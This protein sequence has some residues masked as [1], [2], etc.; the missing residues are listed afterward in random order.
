[1]PKQMNQN[2]RVTMTKTTPDRASR[3]RLL[4]PL[5]LAIP[6]AGASAPVHAQGIDQT[7]ALYS[8]LAFSVAGLVVVILGVVLFRRLGRRKHDGLADDSGLDIMALKQKQLLTPEEMRMVSAAIARRMEEK[9]QKRKRS[10]GI[11]T[12]NLLHDPEVQ[13]LREEAEARRSGGGM[14]P[15]AMA[16]PRTSYFS[17]PATDEGPVDSYAETDVVPQANEPVHGLD[18]D[19]VDSAATAA[20][21]P[22]V[23]WEPEPLPGD[24][25]PPDF[26]PAAVDDGS[27]PPE[28]QQLADAGILTPEELENVKRRLR[29]KQREQG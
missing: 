2:K 8:T 5:F 24:P 4:K 11:T 15:A 23:N 20:P 22:N 10:S 7:G 12:A 1:M 3:E 13:R 19:V 16:S 18:S 29:A 6:M 9:E 25:V 28:V 27:L 17:P 26:Q 21:S 14:P